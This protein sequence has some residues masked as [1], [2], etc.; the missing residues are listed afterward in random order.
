MIQVTKAFRFISIKL[1]SLSL[2]STYEKMYQESNVANVYRCTLAYV[3]LGYSENESIVKTLLQLH[4]MNYEEVKIISSSNSCMSCTNSKGHKFGSYTGKCSYCD[5]LGCK[6][7][8]V[9]HEFGSYT[10]KCKFCDVMG[11]AVGL[12]EHQFGSYTGKCK[13][14]NIMGCV[15]GLSKHQFGSYTGKC[16]FCGLLGCEVGLNEHE[17]GS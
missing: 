15:A 7:G 6:Y 14:C 13:F 8:L 1:A 10:G 11:C 12:K 3:R 16:K 2:N 5:L 17:F 9:N 4:I